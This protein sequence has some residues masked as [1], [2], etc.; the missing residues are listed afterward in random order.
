M[1]LATHLI[2]LERGVRSVECFRD[3]G[4]AMTEGT[5][6]RSSAYPKWLDYRLESCP[7][8]GVRCPSSHAVKHAALMTETRRLA[9]ER[10]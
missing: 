6:R 5:I 7:R 8:G 2:V 4:L 10:R 1:E 3:W 9:E